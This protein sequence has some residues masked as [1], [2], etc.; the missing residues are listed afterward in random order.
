MDDRQVV[1]LPGEAA[2]GAL[3]MLPIRPLHPLPPTGVIAQRHGAGR[4]FE[5]E[6]A[7]HKHGVVGLWGAG[8]K[9]LFDLLPLGFFLCSGDIAG[10][11]DKAPEFGIRDLGG[12]HPKSIDPDA[13]NGK[14]ISPGFGTHASHVELAAGNPDHPWRP[15]FFRPFRSIWRSGGGKCCR[16][17]GRRQAGLFFFCARSWMRHRKNGQRA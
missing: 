14:F 16:T 9:L 15:R 6:R 5:N 8:R 7:G 10:G 13:V 2:P 3:G 4:R 12:I 17:R 1:I 11:F